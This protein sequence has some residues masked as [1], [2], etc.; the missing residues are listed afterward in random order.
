MESWTGERVYLIIDY[1]AQGL[2]TRLVFNEPSANDGPDP[3]AAYRVFAPSPEAVPNLP[4][5][6]VY[7]FAAEHTPALRLQLRL[8]TEMVSG[9]PVIHPAPKLAEVLLDCPNSNPDCHLLTPELSLR[10]KYPHSVEVQSAQPTVEPAKR[11]NR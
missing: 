4:G 10:G 8:S 9:F 1:D 6:V 5:Y 2:P 3:N 7:T 11:G